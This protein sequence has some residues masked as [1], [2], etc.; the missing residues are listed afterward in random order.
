MRRAV[1]D[2]PHDFSKLNNHSRDIVIRN[3]KK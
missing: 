2:L 1:A 3:K